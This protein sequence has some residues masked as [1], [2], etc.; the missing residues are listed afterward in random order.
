MNTQA[1]AI[2]AALT[3]AL[4]DPDDA[5]S[6]AA[7]SALTRRPSMVALDA[8]LD[9][10]SS[11]NASWRDRA[12]RALTVLAPRARTQIE[13]RAE[14]Q[15]FSPQALTILREIYLP[16]D[17]DKKGKIFHISDMP[18][19]RPDR[20]AYVAFALAHDG[21][22][23]RGEKLF[24]NTQTLGCI[25]CHQTGT[26]DGGSI[27]PSLQGVATKYDRAKI[28]ESVIYPSKQ[29]LDGYEQWGIRTQSGDVQFGVIR[30]E[31]DNE[32]TLY[33]S[34][35]NKIVIKKSDIR[36]RA[37][38]PLS[39]MPEG[40]EQAISLQEFADLIGYLESLK[41]KPPTTK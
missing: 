1:A 23:A 22:V 16:L 10:L 35:A 9:L 37:K 38:S 6:N 7:V 40:L 17:P 29:I 14:A 34:A 41:E 27:G 33:D 3:K 26:G 2:P 21:D 39:L 28:I 30:G 8:Y 19:T 4:K 32:V 11:Q 24:R 18:T 5:T 36:Q 31:D 13:A 20:D 12:R 25:R 15:P